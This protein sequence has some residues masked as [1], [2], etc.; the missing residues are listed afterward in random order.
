MTAFTSATGVKPRLVVY[1][2]GWLEP[3]QTSFA[4]TV[5]KHGEVPLVQIDPSHVSLAAIA[6]GQYDAYLTS[7]ARAV[8]AY[9]YPVILGFGHEMNG[10][11]F[12]WGYTA[13]IARD[14]RGRLAACR[15]PLPRAGTRN[16]TWL[17]TVNV[18]KMKHGKI[19]GPAPWWPGS[20]T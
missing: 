1:Y 6:N 5:A 19:P 18:V 9:R 17:W 3:F 16:V 20:R 10:P 12:S 4:A 11:W 8:R 15:H 14:V 2:S 13:H 7:Y